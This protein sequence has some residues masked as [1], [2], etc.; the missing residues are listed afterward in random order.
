MTHHFLQYQSRT[1]PNKAILIRCTD[2]GVVM[3]EHLT[4][5]TEAIVKNPDAWKIQGLTHIPGNMTYTED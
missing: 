1:N 5:R 2:N 3:R 4:P